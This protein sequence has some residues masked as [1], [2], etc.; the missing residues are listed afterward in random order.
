MQ[1]TINADFSKVDKLFDELKRFQD[2]GVHAQ[3][4]Q[5]SKKLVSHLK[6]NVAQGLDAM[7]KPYSDI[8]P[9]TLDKAIAYGGPFKDTRIRREVSTNRTAMNVTGK[10]MDSIYSKRSGDVTEVI[11]DDPRAV[12]VFYSNAGRPG[13]VSKPVRDPLGLKDRNVSD[14]EFDIIADLIDGEIERIV[15]GL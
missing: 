7:G 1:I 12:T 8:D 6:T 5:G 13:N 10:S 2:F 14:T 3:V 4:E 11:V 9:E 15:G